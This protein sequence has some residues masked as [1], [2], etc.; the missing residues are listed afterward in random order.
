[1]FYSGFEGK[2]EIHDDSGTEINESIGEATEINEN[3]EG[4]VLSEFPD[5][6]CYYNETS[7]LLECAGW[8]RWV[9]PYGNMIIT[10]YSA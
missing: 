8:P 5:P 10:S 6:I 2:P 7:G 1:M 3:P 9:K 4:A